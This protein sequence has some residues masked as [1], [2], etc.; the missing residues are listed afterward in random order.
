[1]GFQ[2]SI[3]LSPTYTK[4]TTSPVNQRWERTQRTS[5]QNSN[6]MTLWPGSFTEIWLRVS[7][8]LP[9]SLSGHSNSHARALL[10]QSSE[11]ENSVSLT[12]ADQTGFSLQACL[13]LN[14]PSAGLQGVSSRISVGG[15]LG[16]FCPYQER[17]RMS[18]DVCEGIAGQMHGWYQRFQRNTTLGRGSTCTSFVC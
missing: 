15:S 12:G 14:W 6:T 16:S 13:Y 17:G 18:S 3:G 1:M 10:L 11:R 7:H 8:K 2:G 9:S 4:I 5:W